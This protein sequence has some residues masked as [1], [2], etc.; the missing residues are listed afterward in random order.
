MSMPVVSR[1]AID[2]FNS[3]LFEITD[4][5]TKTAKEIYLEVFDYLNSLHL[6]VPE[7]AIL[8]LQLEGKNTE[9]IVPI[10]EI[11]QEHLAGFLYFSFCVDEFDIIHSHAEIVSQEDLENIIS[12][13]FQKNTQNDDEYIEE[14]DE[15][16][17]N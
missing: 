12:Y 14:E 10:A 2:E 7:F 15:C 4:S 13:S 3:R 5:K 17:F 16:E 1:E 8:G 11:E 9:F 6:S